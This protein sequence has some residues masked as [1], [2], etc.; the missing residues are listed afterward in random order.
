MAVIEEPRRLL[1]RDPLA[2]P[3]ILALYSR[4]TDL[5]QLTR[6]PGADLGPLRL[7]DALTRMVVHL[8]LP[9]SRQTD[10]LPGAPVPTA[11]TGAKIEALLD[12]I[13]ANLE[14]PISLSDLEAQVFWSRRTLQYAFRG[15]C[16]CTPMQWV[17]RRRLHRAMRR[18]TN[19]Q[20]GDTLTS[21]GLSVGFASA[22]AFSRE[23]R[24]QFG[25]P[26]S[27]LLRG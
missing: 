10:P 7:D 6:Q 5:D 20:P 8:L 1:L 26:P 13:E 24:R 22:C 17:R 4:L 9:E 18:L 15:A 14:A 27:S 23:F 25:H 21:I 19:P 2:A 16:G 3:L 11:A 12:W